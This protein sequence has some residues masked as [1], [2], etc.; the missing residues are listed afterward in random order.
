MHSPS[1]DLLKE[2]DELRKGSGR[3][4]ALEGEPWPGPW[5]RPL[6]FAPCARARPFA[7]AAGLVPDS[8]PVEAPLCPPA[9][10]RR[11]GPSPLPAGLRWGGRGVVAPCAVTIAVTSP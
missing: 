7:A 5:R 6:R 10:A 4:R 11:P 8:R 3:R 9:A 1:S 2:R